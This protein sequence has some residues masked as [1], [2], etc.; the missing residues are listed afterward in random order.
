[1]GP[2]SKEREGRQGRGRHGKERQREGREGI[3]G[4]PMCIF[5]S[6]L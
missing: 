3:V 1:M 6:S 2:T 4:D 5:K